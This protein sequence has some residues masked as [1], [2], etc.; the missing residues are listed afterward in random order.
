MHSYQEGS[1]FELILNDA[2]YFRSDRFL[3]KPI[4]CQFLPIF[5][6]R[7]VSMI[8][9]DESVVRTNFGSENLT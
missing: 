3:E 8:K 4:T 5:C 2:S 7:L 6:S 9:S 1:T